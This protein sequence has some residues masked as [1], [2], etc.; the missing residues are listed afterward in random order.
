M[1]KKKGLGK[2]QQALKRKSSDKDS[3]GDE[4]DEKEQLNPMDIMLKK[5]NERA[6]LK[7]VKKLRKPSENLGSKVSAAQPLSD[8]V[9]G[10][11]LSVLEKKHDDAMNS[12][13]N[14]KLG[15]GNSSDQ[16]PQKE[17]TKPSVLGTAELFN[18]IAKYAITKGTDAAGREISHLSNKEGDMGS[19][20][21]ILGGTGIAEVSLK[22]N[23]LF[24][25]GSV[26]TNEKGPMPRHDEDDMILR[27][28]L[29]SS[30]RSSKRKK[31]TSTDIH[32]QTKDNTVAAT[33]VS[34]EVSSMPSVDIKVQNKNIPSSFSHNY[35]RHTHD[36]VT[37]RRADEVKAT[38]V[39]AAAV[40]D[41]DTSGRI[42]FTASRGTGK[43]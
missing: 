39:A 30:F 19:G 2:A 35:K 9:T 13:I 10:E 23:P 27:S 6:L 4:G 16:K 42:G 37:K 40:K 36:W 3:S 32:Y 22:K 29:P 15:N 20:G 8:H 12:F 18:S 31:K 28:G 25:P 14:S 11:T 1:F 7:H 5:K 17:M 24:P 41:D 34:T 38:E 21:N 43:V 33:I 26:S